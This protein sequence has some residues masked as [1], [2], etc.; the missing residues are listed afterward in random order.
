MA[1]EE[2]QEQT[3]EEKL[4]EVIQKGESPTEGASVGFTLGDDSD[5]QPVDRVAPTSSGPF[6]TKSIG[7]V[8]SLAILVLLGSSGYEIYRNLPK[9]P[10]QYSVFDIDLPEPVANL[11]MASL[12]DTL[13]IFS[14]RRILGQISKPIPL[15][16][17]GA[18]IEA[19]KGWRA[20]VRE[21]WKLM[22]T[23]E[24]QRQTA[25][26]DMTK[27]REAIVMDTKDKKMHFLTAGQTIVLT[28]QDV[29]VDSIDEASVA[30]VSGE[31]TLT[32]K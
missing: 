29:R 27:V 23:S 18:D 1:E 7:H 19:L 22:G 30:L 26:G 31:E 28:K 9:A 24:V 16:T 10:K 2:Q 11:A 15:S 3:P 4:L 8:L 6:Q 21:N 5:G 32:I 14:Q 13:N 17:D 25:S 20:F 12:S